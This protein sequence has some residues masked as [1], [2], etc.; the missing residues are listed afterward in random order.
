MK[1]KIFQILVSS[2]FCI[3]GLNSEGLVLLLIFEKV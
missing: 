1:I 3:L 2:L